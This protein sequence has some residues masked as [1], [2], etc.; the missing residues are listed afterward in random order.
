MAIVSA[1]S[2]KIKFLT[3]IPSS[4]TDLAISDE[5]AFSALVKQ[6]QDALKTKA[7]KPA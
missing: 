1:D 7:A 6:A 2:N 4:P 3:D 5:V